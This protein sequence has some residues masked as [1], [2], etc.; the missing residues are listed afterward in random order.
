MNKDGVSTAFE[1]ISEEIESLA[2]GIAEEGG[3]AFK[4][5][6]YSDAQELA[7]TGE[8]LK[9]FKTKVDQLL[10]EWE[11]GFDRVTRTK[12]RIKGIPIPPKPTGR[13]KSKKTRLRVKFKDGTEI[14]EPIAA[15]TFV[16]VL[17]RIG[18]NEVESLGITVR[19]IP[20]VGER[21]SSQYQQRRISGRYVVT[22]SST[23]E[24]ADTLKEIAKRLGVGLNV[25]IIQ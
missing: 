3:K 22:H 8:N 2:E 23:A 5:K 25:D 1:L 18:V 20:L 4:D 16:D 7:D 10:E 14:T 6:R 11:N 17:N 24:K 21:R 13:S 12:T 19:G 15:D 9:A